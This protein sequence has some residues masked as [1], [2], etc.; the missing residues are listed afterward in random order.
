MKKTRPGS[1]FL[2]SLWEKGRKAVPFRCKKAPVETG[3]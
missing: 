1:F 2:V 3:A